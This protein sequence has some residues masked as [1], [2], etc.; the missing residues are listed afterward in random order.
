MDV[1]FLASAFSTETN[2]LIATPLFFLMKPSI[3]TR[4]R[5]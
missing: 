1:A 3:L 5:P 4:L 2:S